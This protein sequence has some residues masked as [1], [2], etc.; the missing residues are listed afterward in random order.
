MLFF[1]LIVHAHYTHKKYEHK[2]AENDSDLTTPEVTV[3]I[4]N[5]HYFRHVHVYRYTGWK[6]S[7]VKILPTVTTHL[8]K[9]FVYLAE[10]G[11]G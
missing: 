10:L 1:F 3:L 7:P 11:L 2:K 4:L 9:L 5:E 6:M 8:K